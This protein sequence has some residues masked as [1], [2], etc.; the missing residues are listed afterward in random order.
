[1]L[2]AVAL[3]VATL[4][5]ACS[6][7]NFQV[8]PTFAETGV[9]SDGSANDSASSL[10]AVVGRDAPI[11]DGDAYVLGVLADKPVGYWRLDDPANALTAADSSGGGH[12]GTCVPPAKIAFGVSGA[13]AT[14][15]SSTAA[16]LQGGGTIV[17]GDFFDFVGNAPFSI[18]VWARPASADST[19]RRLVAKETSPAGIRNGYGLELTR[20]GALSASEASIGFSR[21]VNSNEAVVSAVITILPATYH[22]I[23]VT[24]DGIALSLWIDGALQD[25][26]Q[27]LQPAVDIKNGF[28]LGGEQDG[29][30][31]EGLLDEVAVYDRVLPHSRIVAH[32]AHHR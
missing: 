13:L 19:Y 7:S 9:P 26:A 10:D 8:A 3:G 12:P 29:A 4:G 23:V 6:A 32:W 27:S 22:H 14:E 18:E 31:Y 16:R 1:M 17:M 15:P 30:E 20:Q 25:T 2:S 5:A 11:P 24:Y 21:Y 28:A